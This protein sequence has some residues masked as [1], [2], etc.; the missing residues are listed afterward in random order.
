MRWKTARLN[1]N[2]KI[3]FLVYI[4]LE[5]VGWKVFT[6][7]E[8]QLRTE[9]ALQD[10]I[11]YLDDW[12]IVLIWFSQLNF[13]NRFKLCIQLIYPPSSNQLKEKL[14]KTFSR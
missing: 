5:K 9:L 8:C 1:K 2:Y 6:V 10:I 7:W 3:V 11:G 14:T 4:V 13:F 12:S